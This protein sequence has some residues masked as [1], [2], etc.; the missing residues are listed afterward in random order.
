[1]DWNDVAQDGEAFVKDLM[2][3]PVQNGREL[4][5]FHGVMCVF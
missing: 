4:D 2:N 1:M 5:M 3:M